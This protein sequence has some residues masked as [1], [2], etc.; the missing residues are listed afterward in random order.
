MSANVSRSEDPLGWA[1]VHCKWWTGGHLED[2]PVTRSFKERVTMLVCIY[3]VDDVTKTGPGNRARQHYPA[4]GPDNIT[5]QQGPTTL[6]S[7]RARQHYLAAGPDNIT[8]QQG[9]TTLP[10]SRARQHYPA[11][12]PDNIT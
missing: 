4:A 8:H 10:S 1:V 7:S 5:Q 11:A 3:I 2:E 6:P 12:G 9:P